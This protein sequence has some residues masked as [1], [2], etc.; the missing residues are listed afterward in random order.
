MTGIPAGQDSMTCHIVLTF[1]VVTAR[2]ASGT[3][4][5]RL[6]CRSGNNIR[7]RRHKLGFAIAVVCSACAGAP[8]LVAPGCAQGAPCEPRQLLGE[9]DAK[10]ARFVAAAGNDAIALLTVHPDS[11]AGFQKLATDLVGS[12]ELPK[13]LSWLT[14]REPWVALQ[15]L[16]SLDKKDSHP[17]MPALVGWDTKRPI[18]LSLVSSASGSAIEQINAITFDK[19]STPMHLRI[20]VPATNAAAL[21]TALQNAFSIPPHKGD[22]ISEG[23]RVLQWKATAPLAVAIIA[24][25]DYVR[26][27]LL[28]FACNT[29]DRAKPD[30]LAQLDRATVAPGPGNSLGSAGPIDRLLAN[31]HGVALAFRPTALAQEL[32]RAAPTKLVNALSDVD[33]V[34]KAR[35]MAVSYGEILGAHLWA[36]SGKPEIAEAA[37]AANFDNGFELVSLAQLTTTGQK[38]MSRII[39]TAGTALETSTDTLVSATLASLPGNNLKQAEPVFGTYLDSMNPERFLYSAREAGNVA[40]PALFA[41]P[42][43]FWRNMARGSD[44]GLPRELT[45]LPQDVLFDLLDFDA[46]GVPAYRLRGH[47]T[48][49]AAAAWSDLAQ[50]AAPAEEKAVQQQRA[51]DGTWVTWT[52]GSQTREASAPSRRRA[53]L[54]KGTFVISHVDT[55][56][57]ANRLEQIDPDL[58]R[59]EPWVFQ[60]LRSLGHVDASTRLQGGW[61]MGEVTA[62][63]AKASGL[64]GLEVQLPTPAI[65]EFKSTPGRAALERAIAEASDL[66]KA[67]SGASD[68]VNVLIQGH[69]ELQNLLEQA[70]SDP[71]T[72]TDAAALDRALLRLE[73]MLREAQTVQSQVV[74]PFRAQ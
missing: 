1:M 25:E 20:I 14:I 51:V 48:H 30:I 55:I 65:D 10:V 16:L 36:T 13:E 72:R 71:D 56:K 35:I 33:P 61:L 50:L 23:R 6:T 3:L 69:A 66:L 39:S 49:Q 73:K 64:H 47:V 54:P 5:P 45:E 26:I 28:Y 38:Q 24:A 27:E 42:I 60:L 68:Y 31:S 2:K 63:S 46:Y 19:A 53:A 9:P 4:N 11:W 67:S 12:R 8:K 44:W 7:K 62:G 15:A 41:R 18:V 70:M 34:T 40:W 32:E 17:P 74:V 21:S 22:A 43:G 52:H 29:P 59:R 37:V 57:V 58:E